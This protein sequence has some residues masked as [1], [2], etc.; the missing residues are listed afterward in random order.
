MNN[1]K[2]DKKR[3]KNKDGN[4]SVKKRGILKVKLKPGR[5]DQL[6]ETLISAEKTHL[7]EDEKVQKE[8]A[9]EDCSPDKRRKYGILTTPQ[10][11]I[12]KDEIFISIDNPP[13]ASLDETI[14]YCEENAKKF[15]KRDDFRILI[16]LATLLDCY[17]EKGDYFEMAR[18][19]KRFMKTSDSL[20]T[21][22]QTQVDPKLYNEYQNIYA[23]SLSNTILQELSYADTML[24]GRDPK[25]LEAYLAA[26]CYGISD[27]PCLIIGETGTGKEIIANILHR[28][29]PRKNN[30][31]I[32]VNCGGFTESLY[33]LEIN[34]I[35]SGTA[36]QVDAKIGAF[37]SACGKPNDSK[38][39][40]Y[41]IK[42]KSKNREK[43]EIYCM[44]DGNKVL[45]PTIKQLYPIRGTLFLDEINSMP[46]GLQSTLLR[47][48]QEK[49]LSLVGETNKR[50]YAA[51]IVCASNKGYTGNE[52]V[53]N[54]RSDLYYRISKEIIYL[55]ALRD[56]S[57]A[58]PEIVK[59]MI[60][61]ISRN[62][63][64][65]KID[66]TS[67]ALSKLMNYH[68]PGNHRQLKNV[69]HQ[70]ITKVKLDKEKTLTSEH[71]DFGKFLGTEKQT[72]S[73]F[74]DKDVYQVNKLYVDYLLAKTEGNKEAAMRLGEFTSTRHINQI[75]HPD[76]HKTTRF[77]RCKSL[78]DSEKKN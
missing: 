56:M 70:A 69:L 78:K 39:T 74:E 50:R 49:E 64:Y 37:L 65:S 14:K 59:K 20:K 75:L 63:Q 67:S 72:S 61:E 24:Y 31:S 6:I 62:L 29:S 36:T 11:E 21:K 5:H 46:L 54:L 42:G 17:V 12:V 27:E 28:F 44:I 76:K 66:I 73:F 68:W 1:N 13:T 48:I 40:G 77:A 45:D 15:E 3:K 7:L 9:D 60:K 33:N 30:V 41:V 16:L 55:P 43:D 52:K 58:I 23:T 38:N 4:I 71:I 2:Q 10:S 34:G 18:T 53:D 26:I 25:Q 35:R 32:S 8:K 57:D 22:G 19:Y 47:T 51:K